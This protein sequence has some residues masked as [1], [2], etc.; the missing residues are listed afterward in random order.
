MIISPLNRRKCTCPS[1]ANG[2]T[3]QPNVSFASHNAGAA[4]IILPDVAIGFIKE[5]LVGV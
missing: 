2:F 3:N 5:L 4:L 1:L